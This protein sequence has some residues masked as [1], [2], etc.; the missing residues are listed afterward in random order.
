M[1]K[2]LVPALGNVGLLAALSAPASAAGPA[3]VA[4]QG[5]ARPAHVRLYVQN[6]GG[7]TNV[8]PISTA[9]NKAGRPMPIPDGGPGQ[10]AIT[11]AGRPVRVARK[12]DGPEALAFTPDSKMLYAVNDSTVVHVDTVTGKAGK[13][14]NTG[15]TFVGLVFTPGG[16]TL[17]RTARRPGYPVTGGPTSTGRMSAMASRCPSAPPPTLRAGS[18]R[19]EPGLP[20]ASP[21]GR[22]DRDF[23]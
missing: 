6:A 16:K 4:S 10:I 7:N 8:I 12:P 14:I 18:S 2:R 15:P 20:V 22:G 17:R 21:S 19:S 9:T 1:V 13:P 23:R 11:P 5:A 3:G